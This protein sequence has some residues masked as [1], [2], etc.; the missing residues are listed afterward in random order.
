MNFL[1]FT[2]NGYSRIVNMD[3]VCSISLEGENIC[4]LL[5]DNSIIR[6][7]YSSDAV[8]KGMYKYLYVR[9]SNDFKG[10]VNI[11][12]SYSEQKYVNPGAD[13]QTFFFRNAYYG[14]TAQGISD[15]HYSHEGA[16]IYFELCQFDC[17]Y[18][19]TFG[20]SKNS[21]GNFEIAV[22]RPD[23]QILEFMLKISDFYWRK[24]D[25]VTPEEDIARTLHFVSKVCAIG[26]LCH[27]FKKEDGSKIIVATGSSSGGKSLFMQMLKYV[28]PTVYYLSSSLGSPFCFST[29]NKNTKTICIENCTRNFNLRRILPFIEDDFLVESPGSEIVIPFQSSP[30]MIISTNNTIVGR[31]DFSNTIYFSDFYNSERTPEIDFGNLFF[32][33]WDENQWSLFHSFIME[34]VRTYLQFG[35]VQAPPMPIGTINA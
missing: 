4:L 13:F 35:L 12:E 34:C 2:N 23:C 20:V 5:K 8:A 30:K 14:V 21:A 32:K 9:I 26:W 22:H 11:S 15:Y 7:E 16:Y 24:R 25:G 31:G 10:L 17:R 6:I 33:D 19:E 29:V 3:C 27:N 18:S 1:T 28:Q